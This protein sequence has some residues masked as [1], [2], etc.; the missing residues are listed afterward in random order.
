[1]ISDREAHPVGEKTQELQEGGLR[2]YKQMQNKALP[3]WTQ[4]P[5]GLC[6]FQHCLGVY[7]EENC[8]IILTAF[9]TTVTF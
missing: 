6:E 9:I 3:S 1:M 5:S 2:P 7:L 8:T 4:A